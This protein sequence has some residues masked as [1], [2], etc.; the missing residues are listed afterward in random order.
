MTIRPLNTFLKVTMQ[1][2]SALG[3]RR[4]MLLSIFMT[5]VGQIGKLSKGI[6][7]PLPTLKM[8]VNFVLSI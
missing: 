3:L 7:S 6:N 4:Q 2:I 5:W 1:K 8:E